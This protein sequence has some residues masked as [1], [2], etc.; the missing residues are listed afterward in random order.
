M[1]SHTHCM[2]T[3]RNCAV[4]STVAGLAHRSCMSFLW[5]THLKRVDEKWNPLWPKLTFIIKTVERYFG[6]TGARFG[7]PHTLISTHAY[8]PHVFPRVFV[9]PA[10]PVDGGL[11]GPPGKGLRAPKCCFSPHYCRGIHRWLM[12]DYISASAQG[13]PSACDLQQV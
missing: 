6:N 7:Y 8:F 3:C 4:Q 5:C 10:F 9:L 2:C 1:Q 13:F 11:Y 12:M